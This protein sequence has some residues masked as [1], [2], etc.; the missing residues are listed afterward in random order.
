M[1][2]CESEGKDCKRDYAIEQLRE[3]TG[4]SESQE[5]DFKERK[6]LEAWF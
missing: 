1:G 6:T 2:Q 3:S 5:R 4:Q